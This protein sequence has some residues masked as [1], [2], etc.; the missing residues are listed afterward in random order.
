M[1]KGSVQLVCAICGCVEWVH[2]DGVS[3]CKR[4]KN[5]YEEKR[6]EYIFCEPDEIIEEREC[7]MYKS[8]A[9]G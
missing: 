7:K 1:E 9:C 5:E 6:S 3:K 4:C 2:Q 8:N